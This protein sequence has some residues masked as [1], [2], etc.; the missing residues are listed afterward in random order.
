[1]TLILE[2]NT[3]SWKG[4]TFVLLPHAG[5]VSRKIYLS[6]SYVL[7]VDHLTMSAKQAWYFRQTAK[8]IDFWET[9][10]EDKEYFATVLKYGRTTSGNYWLLQKRYQHDNSSTSSTL[11]TL[12]DL[13]FKYNIKD[14]WVGDST[15]FGN[16]LTNKGKPVI[17]DWGC[18]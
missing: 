9:L 7:K 12:K 5:R 3:A 1:M 15:G 11:Q 17:Y 2:N 13:L 18:H 6:T 10:Q 14:V 4:E 16:W 8:E